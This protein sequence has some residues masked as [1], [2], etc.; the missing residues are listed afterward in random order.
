L[1]RP[2][3]FLLERNDFFR[4]KSKVNVT[5]RES[6]QDKVKDR[7]QHDRADE[8]RPIH[9]ESSSAEKF[10]AT[11]QPDAAQKR[12]DQFSRLKLEQGNPEKYPD[13]E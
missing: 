8:R 10:E 1:R 2:K 5:K 13:R 11:S 4:G 7:E 3:R 12:A 6:I 9:R